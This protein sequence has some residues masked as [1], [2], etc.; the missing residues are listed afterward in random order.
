M[1][2]ISLS[3]CVVS[4]KAHAALSLNRLIIVLINSPAP[5]WVSRR[6][7]LLGTEVVS[8]LRKLSLRNCLGGILSLESAL[9][10]VGYASLSV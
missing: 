3:T 2:S 7:S 9:T 5:F 6:N 4:K 1:N 10:I 8:Y